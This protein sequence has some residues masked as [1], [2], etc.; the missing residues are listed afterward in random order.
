MGLDERIERFWLA[1]RRDVVKSSQKEDSEFKID[2]FLHVPRELVLKMY[3]KING[4][5]WEKFLSSLSLTRG[6]E[7]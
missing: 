5:E 4:G 1:C 6:C 7:R 2:I 3:T